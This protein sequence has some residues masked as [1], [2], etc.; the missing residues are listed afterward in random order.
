MKRLRGWGFWSILAF[1]LLT[2]VVR[3]PAQGAAHAWSCLLYASNASGSS[4]LPV[5]LEGYAPRL[6]RSFGFSNYHLL[7]QHEIAVD[8]EAET[9]LLSEGDIHIFIKNLLLAPDG[10]YV[11][12]LLFVEG[13]KQIIETEARV[14]CESPLFIRGPEWREGQIIIVVAIGA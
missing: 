8:N 1:V 12:G 5:R 7:A 10:R 2:I 4:E 6:K 11:V 14:G 3:A 13:A 9:P